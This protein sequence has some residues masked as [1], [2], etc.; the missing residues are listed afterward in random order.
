MHMTGG[1]NQ[2]DYYLAQ[3]VKDKW[4]LLRYR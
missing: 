2:V 4:K 3:F 1:L